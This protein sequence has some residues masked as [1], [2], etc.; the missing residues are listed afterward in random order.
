M[1]TAER[2]FFIPGDA[3]GVGLARLD[4]QEVFREVNATLCRQTLC[5]REEL[6][7][8]TWRACI[9]PIDGRRVEAAF[10]SARQGGIAPYVSYEPFDSSTDHPMD[11]Y[12]SR[13]REIIGSFHV[14]RNLTLTFIHLSQEK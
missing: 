8:F 2:A 5:R 3:V 7:G 6:T 1:Q 9:D 14:M 10:A 11:L 4:A 12:S 13:D